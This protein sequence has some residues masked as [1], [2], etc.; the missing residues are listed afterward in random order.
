MTQMVAAK[1]KR[2]IVP[3]PAPTAPPLF[4]RRTLQDTIVALEEWQ[5]G[6]INSSILLSWAP[7]IA[8]AC[9]CRDSGPL[10][11]STILDIVTTTV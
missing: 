5:D 1:Y 2:D 4:R 9:S 3:A 10:F 6:N 8:S 7:E 11:T